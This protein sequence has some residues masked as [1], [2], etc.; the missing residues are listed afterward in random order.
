MTMLFDG[1]LATCCPQG[2]RTARRVSSKGRGDLDTCALGM[3]RRLSLILICIL[4]FPLAGV[5]QS[6]EGY[7]SRQ[8]RLERIGDNHVRLIGAV[9]IERDDWKFFA[10]E[11]ELFTDTERL[12]ANGNVVYTSADT[13]LAADRVEFDMKTRTGTFF[14]ATG[15]VS[16]RNA[17]IDRSLFGTQEPDVY[18]YG[19]TIDKLGPRKYRITDGGF[20]TCVQPTPRWQLTTSSAVVNLDDY[21]ILKNTVLK[22]KG[23]PLLYLPVMYYPIQEDDRSTGFL[24]PAYGSSTFRGQSLSNAFFWAINRSNDATI[25]HDWFSTAGQGTGAQ[26]R[27][28]GAGTSRG[29]LTA[30]FLNEPAITL[31]EDQEDVIP[32]RRSFSLTG[33]FNQSLGS[34]LRA[35]GRVDYFSDITVQQTFHTNVLEASRRQRRFLGNVQGNWGSYTLSGT[36]DW[37]ETFFGDTASTLVGSTPRISLRRAERPIAQNWPIYFSLGAEAGTLVRRGR[38]N[39]QVQDRGLTRLDFNPKIRVPFTKWPFLTVNTSVSWRGTYWTERFDQEQALQ[40]NEGIFRQYFDLQSTITG[41]VFMKIWDTPNSGYAERFKH[42]IEP[43]VTVQRATAINNF[44][45]IV[46]LEGTDMVVG[47]VTR[48][49]YGLVNRFLARRRQG[50]AREVLSIS[51]LQNFYT[52]DRAS[53]FDRRFRTSFNGTAPSRL[54][55]ISLLVRSSPNDQINTSVRAEYD[56]R[57]GAFREISASGTLAVSD[58]IQ[59]TGGWSQR[60]YIEGLQGFDNPAQLNHYLNASTI[61]RSRGNR[62]GGIYTFNYDMLRDSFMQQRFMAY[63]NGQCCGISVEYQSFNFTGLRSYY[64]RHSRIPVDRRINVTFTLAGI[65]SFSNFFGAF[66]GNQE[67]LR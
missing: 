58:W 46:K 19:E 27:Y 20:T 48:L 41:P 26:Y 61:V 49:G 21:A 44:N 65:G 47:S 67:Q 29:D 32:A 52:D 3:T 55:P 56:T 30:Y 7:N 43:T 38:S 13:S 51:L 64:G 16:L 45:Q 34:N 28:V 63:Y 54:T 39:D 17:E 40:V 42:L 36:V 33:D 18:F 24:I 14:V 1:V 53:Q 2:I 66:F 31:S 60:R 9:E 11:V 25:M 5:A 22:V 23:V 8:F 15:T 62:A 4:V 10:E 50:D 37:N 12:V 6:L 59:T 35:R 57:Y